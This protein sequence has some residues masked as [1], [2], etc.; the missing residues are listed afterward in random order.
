MTSTDIINFLNPDMFYCII[1]NEWFK[2]GDKCMWSTSSPSLS[3][4][5][6]YE[7]ID[8]CPKLKHLSLTY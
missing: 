8:H 1:T 3:Q 5:D 6:Y 7:C 2:L 4:N